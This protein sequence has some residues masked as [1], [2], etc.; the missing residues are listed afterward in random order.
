MI[1]RV[2]VLAGAATAG[3]AA[4]RRHLADPR[5]DG[6]LIIGGAVAEVDPNFSV[7]LTLYHVNPLNE[8]VVRRPSG[9]AGRRRGDAVVREASRPLG[10]GSRRRRG[11]RVDIPRARAAPDETETRRP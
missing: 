6:N 9:D 8:G 2:L 4:P 11:C 7:N 10:G 5:R 3:A 1:K